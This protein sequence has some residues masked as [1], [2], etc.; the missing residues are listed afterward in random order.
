MPRTVLIRLIGAVLLLAVQAADLARVPGQDVHAQS[1]T[2]IQ[3]APG[4]YIVLLKP[5][6]GVTSAGVAAGYDARPG[7][8]VDHVYTS[9]ISGFAGTIDQAAAQALVNDP[10]VAGVFPD[11][12]SHAASQSLPAG[13][14]RVD[15][16]LNPT[17]A[18]DGSG[19]V[20]ADIA[21]LDSGVADLPDL[22]LAGGMDCT[23]SGSYADDNG[24]G[25]HV[26]GIAAARDNDQGVVG[27]A[28]GARIWAVKILHGNNFG[29]ES[30]I[31]CGL[32]WVA[33]HSDVIDVANMSIQGFY[34]NI[35][36]DCAAHP[37]HQAVC[38]VV[39]R[40]VTVVV[41]A[42][43]ADF[44]GIPFDA[45]EIM[46]AQL[47]EVITVS[48]FYDKDGKPGGLAGSLD[49]T[50]AVFSSYGRDVDISAPGVNI[51]SLNA[52]GG[53]I[54]MSGTS[55][56]SPHVAGGAALIR[57]QVGP[58]SPASVRGR[59]LLDGWSGPI[60]GDP[61]G[62]PEP[63]L[64][65]AQLGLGTISAPASATPG[66]R[67]AVAVGQVV[68]GSRVTFRLNSTS[69]GVVT[70][71]ADGTATLRFKIP[72]MTRGSYAITVTSEQKQLR[73]TIRELPYIRVSPVS[74]GV[75][76]SVSVSLKG[77]LGG[78]SVLITFDAGGA[79]RRPVRVTTSASGAATAVFVVPS[80]VGGSRAVHAVGS[81]GTTASTTFTVK[82]TVRISDSSLASTQSAELTV[83]GYDAGEV[84][85]FR[86]D[87]AD[88]PAL[89]TKQLS[90]IGSGIA[91]V[92]LPD[93]ASTGNHRIYAVGSGGHS[94]SVGLSVTVA[95]EPVT[96]TA[97]ATITPPEG[98][99][100]E[101][102]SP[103]PVSETPVVELPTEIATVT[104]TPS[105]APT[106]DDGDGSPSPEP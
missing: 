15:A 31:I 19:S 42:G 21:V 97:T 95:E 10:R 16:D 57:A 44:T 29:Y 45:A 35:G 68:P 66:S 47:N 93:D 76:S 22:N 99:P 79:I 65:V 33:A 13:I 91:T 75:G 92:A 98:S 87:A 81:H 51:K 27:V 28:P 37:Y 36:N 34:G 85:T 41:A 17:R 89:G 55:M 103:E 83:R 8:T 88:G 32:D 67:I 77:F 73:R 63:A 53:T 59:L 14:D 104:P 48:A 84:V 18:G 54:Y 61:D 25:T 94:A 26:A 100:T 96:P 80:S 11:I 38:T 30:E 62:Y 72:S 43:N 90:S 52:A 12:I 86:W 106:R 74:G 6:T 39:S 71:G 46:P 58:L 4:R 69:M 23:N 78:E 3:A 56:A 49:D 20:D 50:M 82:P 40:G 60:P 1:G 24:H 7:V 9:A 105:A 70:A 64:D 101:A 102:A 5:A 2:T